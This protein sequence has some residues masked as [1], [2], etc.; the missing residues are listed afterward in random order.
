M[1]EE[2]TSLT[3]TRSTKIVSRSTPNLSQ[4]KKRFLYYGN[5]EWWGHF[6]ID[7]FPWKTAKNIIFLAFISV[8]FWRTMLQRFFVKSEKFTRK[9]GLI[10]FGILVQWRK[11][12]FS[13][14]HQSVLYTPVWFL[15]P[16]N[17]PVFYR[18]QHQFGN[19]KNTMI[20]TYDQNFHIYRYFLNFFSLV[21]CTPGYP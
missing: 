19:P 1:D 20:F 8:Y 13:D 12:L 3:Y 10:S 21:K 5:P 16:E 6:G 14:V 9:Y 18:P 7:F 4:M 17:V 11:E 2:I 15:S